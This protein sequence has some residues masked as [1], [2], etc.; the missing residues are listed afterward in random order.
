MGGAETG[1]E[2]V[3][4]WEYCHSLKIS[5]KKYQKIGLVCDK[6]TSGQQ[7]RRSELLLT[8]LQ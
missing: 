6:L 2:K 1:Y 4:K 3:K 7:T 8:D 5:D